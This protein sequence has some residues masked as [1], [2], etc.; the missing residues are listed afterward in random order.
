MIHY[1]KQ[2]RVSEE[3]Y[4]STLET[5]GLSIK[6]IRDLIDLADINQSK[7]IRFCAHQSREDQ[8]HQMFIV[9]PV[10]TYVRPHKHH[11]KSESI[12]ILEGDVDYVTFDS[13][14]SL[15]EV[16]PMGNYTSGKTFYHAIA[17]DIFH[18]L[19]ISSKWL[20]FLEITK[21]PF[22]EEDTVYAQWSPDS[23][24]KRRVDG[25]LERLTRLIGA[26]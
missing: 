23:T 11:A 20:V 9:H 16:T 21:G 2:N 12:L 3:V 22:V 5:F 24:D 15:E 6:E 18:T 25:Y 8:V 13:Q 17:P 1:S 7:K 14:G 26:L 10:R 19:L 4:H